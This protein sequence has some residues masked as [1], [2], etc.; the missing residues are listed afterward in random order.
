MTVILHA[1][2]R[3]RLPAE[4]RGRTQID[5]SEGTTVREVKSRLGLPEAV[6][7]AIN[8]ILDEDPDRILQEGDTIRFFQA[9]HGG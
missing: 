4:A 6:A 1:H 9:I 7:W 8:D 5:L 3:E 2:L